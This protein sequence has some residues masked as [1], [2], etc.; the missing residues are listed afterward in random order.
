[1][2]LKTRIKR[3]EREFFPESKTHLYLHELVFLIRMAKKYD[4]FETAPGWVRSECKRLEAII[5]LH[6]RRGNEKSM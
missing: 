5:D 4:N 6:S 1:M 3:L 2:S